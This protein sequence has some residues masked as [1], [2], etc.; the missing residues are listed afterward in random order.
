MCLFFFDDSLY[1]GY[2]M[3]IHVIL[4]FCVFIQKIITM[5]YN[6]TQVQFVIRWIWDVQIPKL[7]FPFVRFV[8][9]K[10]L[11]RGYKCGDWSPYSLP[12]KCFSGN[13]PPEN[14]N[15]TGWNLELVW[16]WISYWTWGFSRV[17]CS[18]SGV[19]GFGIS[20]RHANITKVVLLYRCAVVIGTKT[21]WCFL[22]KK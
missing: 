19:Y 2:E 13:T 12:Q 18:F 9:Q 21:W 1:F 20:R 4:I 7:S 8:G 15:V 6:N 11:I 3:S 16:R 5:L 14:S 22:E 10:K 17:S